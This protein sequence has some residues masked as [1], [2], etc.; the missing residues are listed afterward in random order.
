MAG[1]RPEIVGEGIAEYLAA[2]AS[3][4]DQ[5]QV[6]LMA[7]TEAETGRAAGMQIG[8][9]QGLFFE[10]LTRSINARTAVEIGT[11]TGYSGLSIARG[12]APGG[13]LYCCDISEEWT[14]IA[15]EH[16]R[17]AGVAERIELIIGPATETLQA[18]A[19]DVTFDLAFI[20]ADKTNYANYYEALLP[21]MNPRGLIL[22]DNTLWSGR[23]AVPAS[24]DDSPDTTALREFNRMVADDSRVQSMILPLGDGVTVIQ[25]R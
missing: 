11:F 4:P 9:D 7:T 22:V 13:K 10:I 14:A 21:R 17:R 6:D 20:D 1:S 23:V 24:A 19:T 16:W 5:V 12:L 18:F 8:H 2:H 3:P 15:Q 25:L